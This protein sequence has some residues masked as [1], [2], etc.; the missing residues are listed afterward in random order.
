MS[1]MPRTIAFCAAALLFAGSG[2]EAA[3][4]YGDNVK[5]K[6]AS[7]LSN[8]TM[9][10]AEVPKNI[11]NTSNQVN[12]LFGWSGGVIKGTAHALGR[13]LSGIVDVFTAPLGNKPIT[14]PPFV[15]ENW[16]TDTTY[17][18]YFPVNPTKSS[19]SKLPPPVTPPASGAPASSGMRY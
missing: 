2:A 12:L 14:N 15:W 8:M 4:S 3:D 16:Y 18:P 5:L 7:G 10:L 1:R 19:G 9:G 17:G 13:T 11:I 6:L